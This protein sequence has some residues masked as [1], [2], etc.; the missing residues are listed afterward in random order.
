MTLPAT[1]EDC[2]REKWE[3]HE[4]NIQWRLQGC[5]FIYVQSLEEITEMGAFDAHLTM[6]RQH[7]CSKELKALLI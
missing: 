3:C 2:G 6:Y 5:S 4:F 7:A 1:G